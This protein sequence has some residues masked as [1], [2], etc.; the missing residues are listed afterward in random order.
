VRAEFWRNLKSLT[1]EDNFISSDEAMRFLAPRLP[2]GLTH[3]HL[4]DVSE[5]AEMIATI[6]FDSLSHLHL[7]TCAIDAEAIAKLAATPWFPALE[8]VHLSQNA[9]GDEG[10]VILANAGSRGFRPRFLGLYD[11]GITGVG[12]AALV[13]S[14]VLAE[15][16]RLV[17]SGNPLGEDGLDAIA[18][19]V[20]PL[21]FI[22]CMD[23]NLS[24]ATVRRLLENDMA[25]LPALLLLM[26]GDNEGVA[27]DT[28]KLLRELEGGRRLR[29]ST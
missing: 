17:V 28:R 19:A 18:E 23:C 27:A 16:D 5:Q 13:R 15:A 14:G 9:L 24:D 6:E 22:N 3:L 26:V 12:L 8:E 2:L 20:L 10:A 25:C 11:N 29:R 1:L 4:S 7:H 21:S